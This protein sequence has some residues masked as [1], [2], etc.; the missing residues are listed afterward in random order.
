MDRR[1][2]T[3][4]IL[5]SAYK[6]PSQD[7]HTLPTT[8]THPHTHTQKRKERNKD[9]LALNSL[10]RPSIGVVEKAAPYRRFLSLSPAKK[11]GEA[12]FFFANAVLIL[13]PPPLF[14][15][16]HL[17]GMAFSSLSQTGWAKVQ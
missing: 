2:D 14:R 12:S 5:N 6:Q 8:P 9:F 16:V 17:V 15:S 7:A 13:P 10:V 4:S 11:K 1:L 3:N